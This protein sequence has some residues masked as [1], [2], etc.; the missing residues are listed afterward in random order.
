MTFVSSQNPHVNQNYGEILYLGINRKMNNKTKKQVVFICEAG[1]IA[2]LYPVL[3]LVSAVFGL[4][5]REIQ[6]RLSEALSILPFF[7]PAAIPGLTVG[8][9]VSNLLT[10]C[11]PLDTLFGS[12]ATLIGAVGAYLLSKA[13]KKTDSTFL[14]CLVPLPNVVS[15]VLIIPWVLKLVYSAEGA[16]Y[17]F[18]I[19]VGAGEI[20]SSMVLG[21]PLLFLLE[22]NKK[23]I[24]KV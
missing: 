12:L 3:T 20:I 15:N 16:V 19:T 23:H 1:L 2:A 8:C 9:I 14:K 6:V 24:F 4:A 10:G 22:K 7:S 21:L 11:M 13:A 18:M 17:Y 5:S